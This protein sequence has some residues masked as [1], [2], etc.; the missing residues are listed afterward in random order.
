MTLKYW[1][2]A[3][4]CLT[5]WCNARC[6]SCYLACRPERNEWM[7]VEMALG[8]WQQLEA[9]SPHGCRVHLAGGE[10][11]GDMPR[12]L[13]I[14]HRAG[15]A[16]LTC[17]KVETNGFWAADET[18]A[19]E[20][21]RDLRETT[22][23]ELLIS[24]DP[25]HQQF[26]PIDVAR[27]AARLAEEVLGAGRW[28]VRWQDWLEQ[29]VDVRSLDDVA[30]Q[31]LFAEWIAQGRDR[32]N[33]RA[34]EQLARTLPRQPIEAFDALSCRE[35]L[36][37]GKH[38]HVLPDG[39]VYPGTCAGLVLGNVHR[40]SI[41]KMWRRLEQDHADRPVLGPLIEGGPVELLRRRAGLELSSRGYASKCHL[42]WSLRKQLAEKGEYAQEISPAW[43]YTDE[44]PNPAGASS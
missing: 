42:C 28:R 23:G 5:D 39:G 18:T 11:F 24:A 33:G 25:F 27:Q 4:L 36:L 21:L 32:L 26:V 16:G 38:V 34:A 14:L 20:M 13:E 15:R 2:A 41:G 17:Q 10:P 40:E 7:D 1:S 8:V 9:L 12:L 3:G 29:G 43:V 6:A 19:R 35:G 37:R 30:R 22:M 31:K 44:R